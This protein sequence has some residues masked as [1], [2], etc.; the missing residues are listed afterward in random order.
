M[1]EFVKDTLYRYLGWFPPKPPSNPILGELTPEIAEKIEN[2]RT[3]CLF[4][5]PNRNLTTL[6]ASVLALHPNCQVMS[7]GG[8]RVLPEEKLN[9]MNGYSEE[10]FREFCHFLWVM[11]QNGDKGSFGGSITITHAFRDYETLHATFRRRYG[12]SLMKR[13]VKSLIWKEAHRTDDY[14]AEHNTDLGA[15]MKK[16]EKLRFILPIRNVVDVTY[17][18]YNREPF[19]KN[20][21]K[22][23][24]ENPDARKILD[25][26][27]GR[28][29]R[30]VNLHLEHPERVLIFF[31]NEIGRDLFVRLANFLLLPQ[32][33]R[34]VQDALKCFVVSPSKYEPDP[35]FMAYYIERVNAL[36]AHAPAIRD[37][38]LQYAS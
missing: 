5:G 37:Q 16:N 4:L 23:Q 1:R 26:L 2:L 19:R 11:S 35:E 7:H 9:F 38:F 27:L 36:F 12:R 6:A 15:I 25:D 22:D 28:M 14:V 10:K 32:D 3:V 29:L 31:E 21:Y 13:D 20:F 34:W 24:I 33:E 18:F 30:T 8:L 17:S